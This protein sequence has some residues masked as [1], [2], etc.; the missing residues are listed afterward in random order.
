MERYL[1]CP[2]AIPVFEDSLTLSR[3]TEAL[4]HTEGHD[5]LHLGLKAELLAL[6]SFFR[7]N[8]QGLAVSFML[9][10]SFGWSLAQSFNMF[11]PASKSSCA[12]Q[13]PN[14]Y[15]EGLE[16]SN[17]LHGAN[18][19]DCDTL[20]PCQWAM[21]WP[22]TPALHCLEST[23]NITPRVVSM[24][25]IHHFISVRGKVSS[26]VIESMTTYQS[27]CVVRKGALKRR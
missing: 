25:G 20:M 1:E 9:T 10:A 19:F 21:A 11:Y 18:L 27:V 3:K 26:Y 24:M 15:H 17:C 14:L 13:H 8:D 7:L 5:F 16:A 6:G 2:A 22:K 4:P 12:S 23:P